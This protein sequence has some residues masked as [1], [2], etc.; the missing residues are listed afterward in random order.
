MRN[1]M[2]CAA[3]VCFAAPSMAQDTTMPA[4]AGVPT[5]PATQTLVLKRD[6]PVELMATSEIR[7]DTAPPG[8]R[9]KLR[10]NQPL[11][12]DGKTLVP[13]GATAFGEVMSSTASGGLGKTGAMAAKL[14]YI[15]SDGTQIPLEGDSSAKGSKTG[16]A[17]VAVL[18]TGVVGLFNRGNNAKIKAGEIVSGFVAADVAFDVAASPPRAIAATAQAATAP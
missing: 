11:I 3:A 17:G 2:L 1:I 8:S 14:L 13:V 4:P 9:F 12:V 6:T 15:D 16:S 7:S 18:L 10:V 5:A